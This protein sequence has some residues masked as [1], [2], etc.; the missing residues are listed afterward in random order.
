MNLVENHVHYVF[1]NNP[2]LTSQCKSDEACPYRVNLKNLTNLNVLSNDT[3]C[4]GFEKNCEAKNRFGGESPTV[5]CDNEASAQRYWNQADFGYL[6]NKMDE[7]EDGI[8]C[9]SPTDSFLHC[10]KH[11][12]MCRARHLYLDMRRA[13]VQNRE[14]IKLDNGG[15]GGFCDLNVEKRNQETEIKRSLSTW[16]EAVSDYTQLNFNPW[17][18]TNKYCDVIVDKPVVFVQLDFGGNMYHHFCDFFNLYLTQMA[19][20]SWF[21]TDVQVIRW[22][23]SYRYGEMFHDAWDAF[24]SHNHISLR[25]YSDKRVCFNDATFAFLPRM[26]LGLFYNTPVE[27]NCRGSSLFRAFAEHFLHRMGITRPALPI[28]PA[29]I[30]ITLMNRG[31]N[32]RYKVYR[33]VLN[34]DELVNAIRNIPGLDIQDKM[35]FKEQLSV[36]HNSDI[37]IGM[38]GAGL[39]HFLFLPPWAV[40]FELYNC[41]DVR[42]YRDLPRLRGVRY[43]TW[44]EPSKIKAFDKYEH[45]HYGSHEKFWNFE[46]DV[47]EFVRL[48]KQAKSMVLEHDRFSHLRRDEL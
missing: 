35:S 16:G 29:N 18:D 27:L 2:E 23:M 38:H 30:K 4:W 31:A 34:L 40:A 13:R 37:F 22:D 10:T 3:K 32:T 25:E 12:S 48:V 33:R 24:T 45:E 6:R 9:D 26:I 46:F 17:S 28:K 8:I 43:M 19:N 42:C 20:N 11:A 21:G 1:S 41:G 44:E 14:S 36:T 7:L 39:T 5:D 15:F 47:T